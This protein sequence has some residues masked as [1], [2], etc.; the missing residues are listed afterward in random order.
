MM[1]T[2]TLGRT[3]LTVSEIGFGCGVTAG[4]MINATRQAR[5]EAVTR[6][7]DLGI[8]YFDTAPV[9]GHS[10]SEANLGDVL[11]ALGVQPIVAT[12]VAL[13]LPDLDDIAGAVVRSV[14]ASLARLRLTRV[15]LVQL[16]NRVGPRRLARGEIGSGA[17]LTV[18]DVLGARGVLDAL[19]SLR[20]RGLVD[21][22]GCCAYG[23]ER[24]AI[25]RVID[26][27]AFDAM[28]V[29]YSMLNTTAWE[30]APAASRLRDYGRVGA[31]AAAAGV[32]TIALRVL[33]GGALS[34]CDV[35]H[36]ISGGGSSPDYADMVLRA[37][38]V[39]ASLTGDSVSDAAIRFALCNPQVSTV[40][41]GFSDVAQIEAAVK[42]A[43]RGPLA[44]RSLS[45]IEQLRESDFGL[46][47]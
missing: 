21:W 41:I 30:T 8:N 6:A 28:L 36:P 29:N 19:R 17:V 18:D 33:E 7:L 34:G 13:E 5:R 24:E 45:A 11:N 25:E 40:L 15:Q 9:Y 37:A 44:A 23:G 14:E 31:R 1:N 39:E 26:S 12:K 4:L 3:E 38:R 47:A 20:R 2:R 46:S 32:G 27:D 43:M 22:F 10:A 35:R 42:S 16:H